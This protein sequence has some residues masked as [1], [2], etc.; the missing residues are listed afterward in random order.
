MSK[1]MVW[2]V[3]NKNIDGLVRHIPNKKAQAHIGVSW[4]DFASEPCN[5][6]VK[7]VV[8][9]VNPYGEKRYSWPTLPIL[10]LNYNLPPPPWLCD[11]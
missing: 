11:Q 2:H 1:F 9:G 6:R 10:L 4:L 5:V 3:E 8:D 7:L